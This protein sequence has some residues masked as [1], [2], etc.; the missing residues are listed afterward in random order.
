[1][2]P[3][4]FVWFV[5]SEFGFWDSSVDPRFLVWILELLYESWYSFGIGFWDCNVSR[6]IR[7]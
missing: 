3:G 6:G 2:D 7:M 4:T 1:M 5:V